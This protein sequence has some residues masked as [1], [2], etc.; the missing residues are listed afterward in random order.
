MGKDGG[1]SWCRGKKLGYCDLGD[2]KKKQRNV[3]RREEAE[4]IGV[5]RLND[6]V[7]SIAGP[8]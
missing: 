4:K 6:R 7:N 5:C 2:K 3:L 8:G 1:L